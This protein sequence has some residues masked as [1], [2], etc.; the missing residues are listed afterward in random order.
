MY[1]Q[2]SFSE[3]LGQFVSPTLG[4][5]IIVA[6]AV[7]V[8]LLSLFFLHSA[9]I[10]TSTDPEVAFHRARNFAGYVSSGWNS[11]RT[12]YNGGKKVVFYLVPGWNTMAKHMIEPGIHIA[13]DVISQVFAG[14]HFE[15]IIADEDR[16]GGVPFR[17]HYCGKPIR[18]SDGSVTGFEPRSELTTKYCSFESEAIWA[19]EL[20]ATPSTDGINAISND[21]LIFSTAHARKLQAL[22]TE[23]NTEEGESMFPALML[24]PLLEAISEISA[25]VSLVTTTFYDIAAHIIYTVLSEL[26]TLIFNVVQVV[27]RAVAAVVMSL[28]SSGAL[29]TLIKAGLDLLLTL[30]VYVAIPLLISVLDLIVCI[31][32]FIQPGTWPEQLRCGMLTLPH[33]WNMCMFLIHVLLFFCS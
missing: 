1:E 11:Y 18:N 12:L 33:S 15:G 27:I 17:G 8:G 7:L 29:Q 23:S 32:N 9:T 6:V 20:G 21:T 25:V 3:L 24:G 13:I 16:K 26:A 5:G 2:S 19:G 30:V 14:H 31:I 4:I 22:F 10:W 28:I